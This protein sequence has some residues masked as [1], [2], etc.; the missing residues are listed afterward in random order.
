MW[1]VEMMW[2][3]D[4]TWILGGASNRDVMPKGF[5]AKKKLTDHGAEY[6]L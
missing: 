5:S 4:V 2:P 6:S 1:K 3:K